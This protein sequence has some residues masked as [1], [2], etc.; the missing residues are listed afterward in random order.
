M[1]DRARLLAAINRVGVRAQS[2][3]VR[4]DTLGA[5]ADGTAPPSGVNPKV[6]FWD[7]YPGDNIIVGLKR[8]FS[9]EREN[10]EVHTASFRN[11]TE[12]KRGTT[13]SKIFTCN[14]SRCK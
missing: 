14:C 12:A 7:A 8:G 11:A 6:D 4:V 1:G 13:S 5:R 3:G 9:F 10:E 2:L